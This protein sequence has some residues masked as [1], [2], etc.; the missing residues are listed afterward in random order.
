MTRDSLALTRDRL[1]KEG[2][3]TPT[4]ESAI[5]TMDALL[6][7]S[8]NGMTLLAGETEA[9]VVA[10]GFSW[11]NIQKIEPEV[12]FVREDADRRK[13]AFDGATPEYDWAKVLPIK[14][15]A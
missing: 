14:V 12:Y 4:I 1:Q 3:Q 2:N 8:T 11:E 5:A 9:W 10:V 7:P 13:A 15:I 6:I